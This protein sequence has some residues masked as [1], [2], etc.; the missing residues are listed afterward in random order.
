MSRS[1]K[2]GFLSIQIRV[3]MVVFSLTVELEIP[4]GNITDR[5]RLRRVIERTG[6]YKILSEVL[7]QKCLGSRSMHF[8]D[9]L[10]HGRE[11]G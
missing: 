9:S 3:G 7:V 10:I 1:F 11:M 8:L 2:D 5:A 4:L 6:R